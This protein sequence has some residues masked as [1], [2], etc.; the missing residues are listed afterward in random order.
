M[1]NIL[2]TVV[3]PNYT[4]DGTDIT[5]PIASLVGLTADEANATDGDGRELIRSLVATMKA[6]I[7]ALDTAS[8]PTKLTVTASNPSG[9]NAS[10]IRQLTT[11]SFDLE[12]N[13]A[14]VQMAPEA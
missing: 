12:V 10:S 5:I 4:T 3:F 14:T 1:A 7:D 8:K 2:P 6:S 11:F 13:P 9:L